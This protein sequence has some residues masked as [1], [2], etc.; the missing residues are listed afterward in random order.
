[1]LPVTAADAIG[2]AKS[3]SASSCFVCSSDELFFDAY[4]PA[5]PLDSLLEPGQIYFLLPTAMLDYPLSGSDMAELAMRASRAL[6]AA[7]NKHDRISGR[8]RVMPAVADICK[9]VV[10]DGFEEKG[11]RVSLPP[12]PSSS[13]AKAKKKV[14][15]LAPLKPSMAYGRRTSNYKHQRLGT[16]EE[17]DD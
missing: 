10:Q 12:P 9:E 16:I 2:T 17:Q 5:M 6:L 1:M 8:N 3:T 4:I 7:S 14:G 13:L 15:S 11:F